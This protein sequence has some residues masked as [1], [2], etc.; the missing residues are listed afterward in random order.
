MPRHSHDFQPVDYGAFELERT[1][2][3]V[4]QLYKMIRR[5]ILSLEYR[6][7]TEISEAGLAAASGVSRT[8]A[9]QVIK[10]LIGERLLEAFPSQGTFVSR[11]DGERLREALN[12]RS[13]LE[14]LIAKERALDENRT[15]LIMG[16]REAL[17]KQR[18][19]LENGD[20]AM[21]YHCDSQ[22]HEAICSR[23]PDSF[24]W[25]VIRQART[26][27]DRLHALSTNKADNLMCALEHHEAILLAIQAGDGEATEARMQE[28]MAQNQSMFLKIREEDIDCF[29]E[30]T[31]L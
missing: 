2:P 23:K 29:V 24:L 31:V 10:D 16:L 11:I 9:R 6:P 27:G 5:K 25:Q 22:F 8:P 19:A 28:H 3:I 4:P 13:I 1:A 14:P 20:S 7:G 12:V 26:E 30:G 17:A 18:T 15:S 21:A